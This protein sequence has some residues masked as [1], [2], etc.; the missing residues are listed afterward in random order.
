MGAETENEEGSESG[1]K[2]TW[3]ASATDDSGEGD[4]TRHAG[5]VD[6]RVAWRGQWTETPLH[7]PSAHQRTGD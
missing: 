3:K 7:D 6:C 1:A 4:M 2:K 5:T